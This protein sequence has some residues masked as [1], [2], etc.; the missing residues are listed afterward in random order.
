MTDQPN[1]WVPI[2]GHWRLEKAHLTFLGEPVRFGE[3]TGVSV[4]LAMSDRRF[5]GG[6]ISATFE[7]DAISERTSGE[8]VFYHDPEK[9]WFISAGIGGSSSMYAIRHWDGRWVTHA[10]AGDRRNLSPNRRYRLR[11]SI[12]GSRV[13]LAVDGV[14]VLRTVLPFSL[15]SSFVGVKEALHNSCNVTSYGAVRLI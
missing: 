3:Q 8:I 6:E 12:A 9:Q 13:S 1:N 2:E 11:V 14:D 10:A 7:F 4:G 15:Q 5:A